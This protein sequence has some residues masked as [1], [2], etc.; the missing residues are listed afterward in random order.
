MRYVLCAVVLSALAA[1]GCLPKSPF[2]AETNAVPAN[3]PLVS[4]PA[5]A[6]SPSVR[7]EQVREENAHK[8]AEALKA[9]LEGEA[10]K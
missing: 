4:R 3:E 5:K 8:V 1:T 6:K 7:P 10:D 9:E 2:V